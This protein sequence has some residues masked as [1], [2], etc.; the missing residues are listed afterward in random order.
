[1][2][3][4]AQRKDRYDYIQEVNVLNYMLFK[5]FMDTNGYCQFSVLDLHFFEHT[6]AFA[7]PK[8]SPYAPSFSEYIEFLRKTGFIQKWMQKYLLSADVCSSHFDNKISRSEQALTINEFH[9][10]FYIV[11]TGAFSGLIWLLIELRQ[12]MCKFP[13]SEN[14][15]NLLIKLKQ[16][17]NHLLN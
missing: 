17:I 14:W 5:D 3:S 7:F 10:A 1:M 2:D 13:K 12:T 4:S 6:T 9:S 16:R 8:G 15:Q 11:C